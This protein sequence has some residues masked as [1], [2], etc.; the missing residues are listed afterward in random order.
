MAVTLST[1]GGGR[2]NWPAV[3]FK[4]ALTGTTG[5]LWVFAWVRLP[6]A[7]M[8]GNGP[9]TI[10]ARD[11][12]ADGV[13]TSGNEMA[14]SIGGDSV[15]QGANRMRPQFRASYGG[16]QTGTPFSFTAL[17]AQMPRDT[18]ILIGQGVVNT[19]TTGSPV[20]TNFMVV[21]QANGTPESVVMTPAPAALFISGTGQYLGQIFNNLGSAT[22]QT[23]AGLAIEHV[24]IGWGNFPWDAANS[25]PDHTI[26]GQL[27]SGALLFDSASVLNG[28]SLRD[29]RKLK[30]ATDLADSSPQANGTLSITGTVVSASAIAPGAWQGVNT[31]AIAE[32][33]SGFVFGG[34]GLRAQSFSGTY[35]GDITALQRRIER[36][37]G[38]ESSP[39]WT[40]VPGW[41]WATA[42]GS[43][44]GGAWAFTLSG[45]G[46]PVGA[47]YRLRVR[48]ATLTEV[49]T[50]TANPWHVG[51]VAAPDGQSQ[52][53]RAEQIGRGL[54]AP[55]AGMKAS[56]MRLG[57]GG[58]DAG[59]SVGGGGYVQPTVEIVPL[60]TAGAT[61]AGYMAIAEAYWLATGMPV[62]IID[63]P[64][65][66][67]GLAQW[68][69]NDAYGNFFYR[70]DGSSLPTISSANNSGVLT[71]LAIAAERY[72]DV[73]FLNWGTSDSSDVA[74]WPA[75]IAI[76]RAN[77]DSYFS[78]SP[79][80]VPMLVMPYPRS[81]GGGAWPAP[82]NLRNV[83]RDYARNTAR[84]IYAGD[85]LDIIM[86]ADGS[87][88]PRALA[89]DSGS[90]TREI[91]G[92]G[93][94]RQGLQMGRAL[95]WWQSG[96]SVSYFGP[97]WQ[98]VYFT[99]GVR[100]V[101]EV[102]TGVALQTMNSA[103]VA[104]LMTVSTDGG[105][106]WSEAGFTTSISG[107]KIRLT[108]T[109]GSWTFG[110]TRVDYC[111]QMPFQSTRENSEAAA[112]S[113]VDGLIYGPPQTW[114]DGRGQHLMP[115]G[116]TGAAV[117]LA[118]PMWTV[119]A[120]LSRTS[121]TGAALAPAVQLTAL[122]SLSAGSA[123]GGGS[124][125]APA[126]QWTAT[127]SLS[128]AAA[129]GAAVAPGLNLTAGV[130]W[131]PASA[132][133]AALAPAATWPADLLLLT[134]TATVSAPPV[135]L[136]PVTLAEA[137]AWLSVDGDADDGLIAD[138]VRAAA[139]AIEA[140][141]GLSLSPQPFVW[142]YSGFPADRGALPLWRR[143]IDL[144]E[145]VTYFSAADGSEVSIDGTQ[146]RLRAQD[147]QAWLLPAFGANW[148]AAE[149][150]KGSV[151]VAVTAGHNSNDEVPAPV[152]QAALSLVAHW[153]ANREAVAVGM[154]ELPLGVK[155]L[156]APYRGALIG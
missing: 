18:P 17:A 19:G 106:T 87:N 4:Q 144:V 75:K 57:G 61:G 37:T 2:V 91:A 100:N 105:T 8:A 69:N 113:L 27:A 63:L 111:R 36:N 139:G 156:L 20:W 65:E 85:L 117:G 147:N 146:F 93:S 22:F 76:Y 72:R 32:R 31:I 48:D 125:S 56:V 101:I 74:G 152:R 86:D 39:V 14:W 46:L 34:M 83:Q 99:D 134:S 13:F 5:G 66:G 44:S 28:G 149:A 9:Y 143:P 110:S 140:H 59:A 58:R 82:L 135:E 12:N 77:K 118:D 71:M 42:G 120:S 94:Q 81:C 41:D 121:A 10:I 114:R 26:V 50:A 73:D 138:L 55:P 145:T 80:T 126:R 52:L 153:Y 40:L 70:G 109:S 24:A 68:N 64:I 35:Q 128:V 130:V 11:S 78:N 103:A 90:F 119:T 107:T 108:K 116:G 123:V 89:A 43:L 92:E 53:Q 33:Q 62:M 127:A 115:L 79:S 29:W 124:S 104:Q 23:P 136:A 102:E 45:S 1:Q 122:A 30:T 112:A 148:P 15:S 67:S 3:T 129:T 21:C 16:A 47:D 49:E 133:G 96:G 155:M 7:G 142:S 132:T 6:S 95:A 137:K 60:T 97:L 151:S 25:R 84:T 98:N 51:L 38:T 141:T 154:T 88:H 131:M 54:R 150:S